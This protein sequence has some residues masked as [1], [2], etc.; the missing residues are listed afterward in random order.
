VFPAVE[1]TAGTV[2]LKKALTGVLEAVEDATGLGEIRHVMVVDA[3]AATQGSVKVA[4]N[5]EY[6]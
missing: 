5:A 2:S 4:L 6:D 1:T 3:E